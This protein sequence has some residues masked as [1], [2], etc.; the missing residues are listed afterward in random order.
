[1]SVLTRDAVDQT[2]AGA[3]RGWRR[4]SAVRGHV[5]LLS[6]NSIIDYNI[7]V[8]NQVQVSI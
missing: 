1:M 4:C 7:S 8:I 6:F 5:V 3:G 2:S